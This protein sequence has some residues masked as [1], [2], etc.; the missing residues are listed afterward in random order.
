M[1]SFFGSGQ[2]FGLFLEFGDF[3][4][5]ELYLLNLKWLLEEK[6][7]LEVFAEAHLFT[8]CEDDPGTP[9]KS[10]CYL[11]LLAIMASRHTEW[12]RAGLVVIVWEL[13]SLLGH[14]DERETDGKGGEAFEFTSKFLL[15]PIF[16]QG[17]FGVTSLRIFSER[18]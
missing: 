17:F 18:H 10:I 3:G 9:Y 5:V 15:V 12:K 6:H 11:F 14:G 16:L 8:K 7:H 4:I 13:V 2:Q 1:N